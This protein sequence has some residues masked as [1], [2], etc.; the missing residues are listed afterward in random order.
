MWIYV[1]RRILLMIPT[2]FGITLI[3]FAVMQLAPGDPLL[4]Q[5]GQS[6]NQQGMT[7]EAYLVQKRDLK[8]DKPAFLNF[9]Y[10]GDYDPFVAKLAYYRGLAPEAWPA[11]L[12]ALAKP[13]PDA[14]AAERL[15]FLK[16]LPS[17]KKINEFDVRLKDPLAYPSLAAAIQN[18]IQTICEDTGKFGVQATMKLLNTTQ[19]QQLKVGAIRC[20]NVMIVE[21]FLYTFSRDARPEEAASV[22]PVWKLWWQRNAKKFPPLDAENRE[23]L[24]ETWANLLK[25]QSPGKVFEAIGEAAFEP[26]TDLPFFAQ[27][28]IDPQATFAEQVLATRILRLFVAAPL[29]LEV[30]FDADPELL[31][32]VTENWQTHYDSHKDIY[33]P[34]IGLQVY[35]IFGDTQY[36]HMVWRLATFDFGRSSLKTREPVAEKLWD[37][38]VVS[39]PIMLF[40]QL[41]I[42]AVAV[43]AGLWSAATRGTF[44]DRATAFILLVLYSF[45][46]FVAASLFLLF[47]CYGKYLAI[48]PVQGLHSEGLEPWTAIWW[49]DYLWHLVLPVISLSIFSMASLAAYA[50]AGMVDVMGQDYIR[51]ARSV[52][53]D[54]VT[55]VVKH[56][57]RNALIP[58]ITIFASFLPAMLGGSV[59]IE[60]I[61]NI[62]G[63]GRLGWISI[64]QKDTPTLMALIYIDALVVMFSILLA[65]LLYVLADPRISF[66]GQGESA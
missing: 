56:A 57:L 16:A 38:F 35:T 49:R 34:S 53:V 9:Q 21:P 59:L 23:F 31:A 46:T 30:P 43:P 29:R 14:A 39:A 8:L 45:P 18:H 32:E 10:F 20:L 48:F 4:Q 11:E 66:G 55:I 36:A 44:I 2:L 1:L 27:R 50:R 51:T 3:S 64:E 19:E 17:G 61:F 26:S 15:A 22:L 24:E 42:Y 60:Y 54:Q 41:L 63:M 52:G 37:G 6:G 40:S 7:R 13:T 65:D 28:L 58:L 12:A 47:F 33:E 5:A 62:P 25:I